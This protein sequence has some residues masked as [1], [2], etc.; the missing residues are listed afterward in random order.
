MYIESSIPVRGRKP[1]NQ[2]EPYTDGQ[3]IESS[4]PVRGR[5]LRSTRP[6][7]QRMA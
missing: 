2:A 4:I 3:W 5:K 7:A 1:V 6:D